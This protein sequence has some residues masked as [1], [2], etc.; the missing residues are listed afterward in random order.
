[1]DPGDGRICGIRTSLSTP[2]WFG[3]IIE[4]YR[5]SVQGVTVACDSD[6]V[7]AGV[8]EVHSGV[9]DAL[10]VLPDRSGEGLGSALLAAAEREGVHSL[11]VL[12]ENIAAR[13]FY[14]ARGWWRRVTVRLGEGVCLGRSPAWLSTCRV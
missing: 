9:P 8:A 5:E 11:W 3:E 14:E 1:V 13:R 12:R 7:P 2:Y 6:D 4:R 10:Y